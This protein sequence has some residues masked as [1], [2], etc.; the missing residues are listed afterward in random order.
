MLRRGHS[1]MSYGLLISAGGEG[2]LRPLP[3]IG[4]PDGNVRGRA[5]RQRPECLAEGPAAAD[6]KI[7]KT[8]Q[9]SDVSDDS[10]RQFACEPVSGY[11]RM[12]SNS[13]S[14][15]TGPGQRR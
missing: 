7:G 12:A 10:V 11:P 13:A 9:G 3:M 5:P 14:W 8:R 1:R 2:L 15:W 4:G 6:H